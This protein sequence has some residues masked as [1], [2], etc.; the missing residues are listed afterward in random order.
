MAPDVQT[1]ISSLHRDL[2]AGRWSPSPAE[3]DAAR[4]AV[5]QAVTI[6]VTPAQAVVCGLWAVGADASTEIPVADDNRLI[7]LMQECAGVLLSEPGFDASPQ[8]REI[9]SL[10]YQL[11]YDADLRRPRRHVLERLRRHRP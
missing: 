9:D 7:R 8:G 1:A 11:L 5:L 2:S 3:C 6:G 4:E 10:L